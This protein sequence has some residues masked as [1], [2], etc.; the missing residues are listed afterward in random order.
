[1]S[2]DPA[3]LFVNI[4]ITGS[5]YALLAVGL[6]MV[7]RILRFPNF[8]H[9]ELITTG[10]YSALF[11]T[12]AGVGF[13]PSM[14]LAFLVAGLAGILMDLAVFRPLRN[15]GATV[16]SMMIASIGVGFVLR[17]IIQ[18]VFGATIKSYSITVKS[19]EVAGARITGIQGGIILAAVLFIILFHLLLTR[20]KLG[21]AMR[22]TSD[23][24]SLAMAS[25][26]PIDRVILGVWFFGGGVAGV[27][28]VFRGADT[29]LIPTLGW[30]VLLFIFAV[31]LLGGIGSIYG[32]I[33]A[34]HAISAVENLGV[35]LLVS[36]GLSTSYRAAIA[37]LVL[38]LVLL[39]RPQG[40]VGIKLGGERE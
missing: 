15:K 21:K 6:T 10:A 13:V 37:F 24:P 29:R 35:V 19:Y 23:N 2:V 30:E 8:A 33:I 22:A 9:A 25:G 3:Q 26:I 34:A 28:G 12:S 18:E 16:I 14:A 17:H 5:L 11:F 31:V 7:Y 32:T 39:F 4:L 38:I 1:M 40:I 36:L 27:A 20:T